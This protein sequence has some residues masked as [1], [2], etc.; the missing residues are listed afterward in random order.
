MLEPLQGPRLR[1]VLRLGRHVRAVGEVR[2][3]PRR[4]TRD[5]SI[6]GQ[7]SNPDDLAAGEDEPRDPRHR[8]H[9]SAEMRPT[10]STRICT[11]DLKADFVLANPPFND[12]RLG[13]RAAARGRRAGVRRAAVGNANFAWVQHFIDHLA[14]HGYGRVRAGQR[15]LSSQQ[16]GEGEIRRAII[17]A[18]LVDCIVSLPGQL[19]FTTQIPVSL[20][21]LTRDK[22][23]GLVR[24]RDCATA[25]A[26]PCS[27]T[28]ASSARWKTRTLR[29]F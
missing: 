10:A 2:R 21:F 14:P 15:L 3:G 11:P 18:D 29:G 26:R 1:P 5:I 23:N 4:P 8:G 12:Q 6:F 28:P 20:W 24:D 16:S 27:S 19:F 13:R 17:E 22:S 9:I 25:R 7:E